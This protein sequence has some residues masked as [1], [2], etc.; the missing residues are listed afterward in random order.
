MPLGLTFCADLRPT[1]RE[2]ATDR[3]GRRVG[4]VQAGEPDCRI[5]AIL[6]DVGDVVIL[7][8]RAVSAGIEDR[9]SLPAGSFL[10]TALKSPAAKLATVGA[11]DH[12]EWRRRIC[13]TLPA[14]AVD[15]WLDYH[16]ELN[17]GVV[18]LLTAA[19]EAGV[20]VVF[21]SN[22]TARLWDDL[23]YHGILR[24]ADRVFCSAD[25]AWAKPDPRAYRFVIDTASLV[26]AQTLYVDDTPSWV[27]MGRSLGMHGY[28][29]I[30]T[31]GLSHELS[32]LG[33]AVDQTLG[34]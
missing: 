24:F 3:A 12:A 22:A 6:C 17:Q 30:T 26:L 33:V 27:E 16:G 4:L 8:D 32:R 5:G 31:S 28:V 14:Q 29:Y 15:E 13:R 7:F 18:D 21:L 34:R 25:I 9:Y 10:Q 2:E 23:A 19:K 1:R 11:I 20:R